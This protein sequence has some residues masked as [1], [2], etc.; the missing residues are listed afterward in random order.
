MKP[1]SETQLTAW[2]QHTTGVPITSLPAPVLE[3]LLLSGGFFSHTSYSWSLSTLYART[4]SSKSYRS[5]DN[6]KKQ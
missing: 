6:I 1:A 4:N 2:L 3:T 5:T